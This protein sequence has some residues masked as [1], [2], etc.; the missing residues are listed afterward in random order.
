MH[1]LIDARHQHLAVR[2]ALLLQQL[3]MQAQAGERRAQLMGCVCRKQTFLLQRMV[4]ARQQLINCAGNRD[5]LFH[6]GMNVE[7]REVIGGA[8]R[9]AGLQRA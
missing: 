7:R 4:K 6:I 8:L 3:K 5:D 9:Q 2:H 1:Q